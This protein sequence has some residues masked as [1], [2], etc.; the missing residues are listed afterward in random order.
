MARH[1]R[2]SPDLLSDEDL[3]A[4]FVHV[5]EVKKWSRSGSTIALCAIKFFVEKTLRRSWTSLSFVRP[6]REKRLPVILTV[7]EVH[8][9]LRAVRLRRFRVCL[10][11]IY[12][13]GLRLGEGTRLQIADI[14]S[15]RRLIH[16]RQ[17]KGGRDRYV[18]LPDSALSLLREFWRTH[19]NAV[20]LFPA[21]GRGG[22]GAATSTRPTPRSGVQQAF[23]SAVVASGIQKRACVHTLRHSWATHLLERNVDLRSIQE[24][25]GHESPATTAIYTHLTAPVAEAAAKAINAVMS[26]LPS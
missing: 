12:A 16:V 26:G 24:N 25:L 10:T 8:R 1:F 6:A 19:R 11:V 7:E 20:W 13:C 15:A 22:S 4:Y 23:R 3:R 14:D 5:K 21:P 18:L 9:I 17:G 2:K